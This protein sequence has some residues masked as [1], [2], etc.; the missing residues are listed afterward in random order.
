MSAV[1]LVCCVYVMHGIHDK[2]LWTYWLLGDGCGWIGFVL[3]SSRALTAFQFGV[4]AEFGDA[5][6]TLAGG[7]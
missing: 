5:W 2:D 4:G 3:G 6:D 7:C 1:V